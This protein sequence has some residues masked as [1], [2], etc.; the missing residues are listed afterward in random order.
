MKKLS[1]ILLCG[2]LSSS[3]QFKPMNRTVFGVRIS[4]SAT[5]SMYTL[6][7]FIHDGQ[8]LT[9][10]KIL[11]NKDFAF[12]ASGEWPSIY[13]P[14]RENLFDQNDV[15]GG[16]YQ[17]SITLDKLPYCFALDSLWKVRFR[18]YPFQGKNENGWSQ[19]AYFPSLRQKKYLYDRYGIE[20]IDT[21]FFLD[22]S[23]WKLLRDVRDPLWISTY[24]SI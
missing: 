23:F 4:Y 24:R 21:K 17:D 10:K 16:V 19:D 20:Q 7:V 8:F 18:T 2:L 12:F 11:S 13:N 1:L 5:G 22:T 15:L 6:A 9:K 14:N 3:I